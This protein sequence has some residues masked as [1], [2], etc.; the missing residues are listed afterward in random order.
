VVICSQPPDN[1]NTS[2]TN[3]A[4]YLA[5]EGESRADQPVKCHEASS[6]GWGALVPGPPTSL[7]RARRGASNHCVK[8]KEGATVPLHIHAR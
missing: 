3:M 7:A 2:V 4:E 1:S 8:T 5:A 6:R